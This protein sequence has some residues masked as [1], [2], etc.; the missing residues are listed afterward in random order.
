MKLSTDMKAQ[1]FVSPDNRGHTPEQ[2]ADMCVNRILQISDKAHPILKEQAKEFKLR[3]RDQILTY[4]KKCVN[5]DRTT[6]Y[7]AIRDAGQPQ[8]AEYIRK[9]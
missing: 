3:M 2:M 5:S 6:V 1:V 4:M 9:L 7:N 8:L